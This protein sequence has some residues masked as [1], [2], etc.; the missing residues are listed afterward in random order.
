[1]ERW[2]RVASMVSSPSVEVRRLLEDGYLVDRDVEAALQQLRGM[3]T[4]QH[5]G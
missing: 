3:A 1:V 5:A 2:W 4:H